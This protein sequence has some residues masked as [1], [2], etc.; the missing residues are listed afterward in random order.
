[1]QESTHVLT[2]DDG[3]RIFLRQWLADD[4]APARAV[5]Q[6][7]HGVGEHGERYRPI[8]EQ[9]IKHGYAVVAHDHRG[10]GK[11]V[12][13][14]NDLGYLPSEHAWLDLVEDTH[15][16]NKYAKTALGLNR[17]YMLGHS[18]GSFV[19]LHYAILHGNDIEAL[20]LTGSTAHHR[21]LIHFLRGIAHIELIRMGK[22]GRSPLLEALA[23]GA[24]NMK[25]RPNR[26]SHDWLSRDEAEVD[27]Y[28]SDPLCGFSCTTQLW[29][30]L[31]FGLLQISNPRLL[32]R[33][34]KT[35]PIYLLHGSRDPVG[36]NGKGVLRLYRRLHDARISKVE[37]KT[38][39]QARHEILNEI[40][41]DEVINDIVAWFGR[42]SR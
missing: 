19:A 14:K 21:Q 35:L 13:D 32:A 9:L 29:L 18:M 38:Y 16:V 2:A 8:A 15:R 39:P 25:F 23:F 26:S 11:S 12:R 6:I 34:P 31:A 1:M 4:A 22:R 37:M 24:F 33:I 17:V 27:K 5:I 41:R 20:V 28:I 7:I 36:E 42:L 40:N 10:H 30:A 3:H